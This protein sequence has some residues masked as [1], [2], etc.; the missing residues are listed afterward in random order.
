MNTSPMNRKLMAL[1][2]CPALGAFV[3]GL[4]LVHTVRNF[5]RPYFIVMVLFGVS[6]VADLFWTRGEVRRLAPGET[7]KIHTNQ[8]LWSCVFI[9]MIC[10]G[11]GMAVAG[12][13]WFSTD[14]MQKFN[15]AFWITI[16]VIAIYPVRRDAKRLANAAGEGRIAPGLKNPGG[17]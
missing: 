7:A 16:T 17:Q 10:F 9:S 15:V 14:F 6:L 4:C 8:F 12:F 1:A 3:V 13:N 11:L 5:S 2:F